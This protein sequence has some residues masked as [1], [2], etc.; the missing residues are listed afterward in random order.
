[1]NLTRARILIAGGETLAGAAL[2]AEAR[3]RGLAAT[4]LSAN[5]T[6]DWA[7]AA[8]IEKSFRDI[9]P[10]LVLVAAGDSGGIALNRAHPARLM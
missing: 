10:D 7:D 1:M 3:R 4:T 5:E 8:A 2:A 6:A 9:R